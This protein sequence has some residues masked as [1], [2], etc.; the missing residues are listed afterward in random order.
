[1]HGQAQPDGRPNRQF[2]LV[3]ALRALAAFSVALTHVLYNAM[4]L[5]PGNSILKAVYGAMPW[6][7]GVDIFFVISGFVIVHSSGRLFTAENA[8]GHFALRR[9]AR[10]V[11]LYWLMTSLLLAELA[12]DPGAVNGVIGGAGY[13]L[14][15]Y[16]FIPC[17]RPDGLVQPVL[18]LG[19]TLNYEMFFY[20]V[21][22]PFLAFRRAQAVA[23]V[24]ALLALLVL[25]GRLGLL[26]GVVLRTW[27]DPIILEF[28]AGMLLALLPGRLALHAVPRLCIALTALLLFRLQPGLPRVLAD[29]VPAVML[30]FAA[31]AGRP[32][33]SLPRL[34]RWLVRLGDASY[35]LYL[36]HPFVMRALALLWRQTQG[37]IFAYVV[38]S[39][40]LAQLAALAI[41]RS[42]EKPATRWLRARLEPRLAASRPA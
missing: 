12:L 8:A 41:H 31:T 33:R 37:G 11:P 42:F 28:C 36:V 19:W 3:Q 7:A 35:A 14:S 15:S 32:S 38:L 1:M 23:A 4:A 17:A 10:I 34:E 30:V 24:S 5:A 27:S 20:F 9:L 18:G 22:T 40:V 39:L 29:G 21:F 2:P 26:H 25:L 13:I 6:G 16:L